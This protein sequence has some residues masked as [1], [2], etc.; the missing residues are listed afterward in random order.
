MTT[1]IHSARKKQW[2]RAIAGLFTL[3]PPTTRADLDAILA[4]QLDRMV[5]SVGAPPM[6][7]FAP[8]PDEPD[9]SPFF[10]RWI[11]G[12]GLLALPVWEG[13]SDMR[14]RRVTDWEHDLAPD[15]AGIPTPHEGLPTVRDWDVKLVLT[16]GRA[17]S[18]NGD[19]LGR[20]EGCYDALFGR[21]GP[22]KVGVAYDFQVFPAIPC[23]MGDVRMDYIV[24]PS[25]IVKLHD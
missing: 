18:E 12:G 19:R 21:S 17:F 8:L 22:I 3:A 4:T 15:K 23:D 11:S 7:G 1:R 2:R 20:G 16:P 10:K 6:L 25:R 13:G 5:Q 9:I 14:L 24:T